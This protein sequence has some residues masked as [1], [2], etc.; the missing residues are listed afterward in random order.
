RE[1][2]TPPFVMVLI[3]SIAAYA[4][5]LAP[6]PRRHVN[7]WNLFMKSSKN[8]PVGRDVHAWTRTGSWSS[9]D[10]PLLNGRTIRRVVKRLER[11]CAYTPP[12]RRRLTGKNARSGR[13]RRLTADRGLNQECAG[14]SGRAQP[15]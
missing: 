2:N 9:V 10:T 13:S 11:R 4:A 15:L 14:R 12:A 7:G 6:R 1:K 8:L 5:A 3:A